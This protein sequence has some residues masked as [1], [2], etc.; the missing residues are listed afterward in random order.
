VA[1]G[2]FNIK[3]N[4]AIFISNNVEYIGLLNDGSS[5]QA[6]PLFVQRGIQSA[7]LEVKKFKLLDK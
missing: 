7:V 2:G 1:I 4:S 3:K 6:K 5:K